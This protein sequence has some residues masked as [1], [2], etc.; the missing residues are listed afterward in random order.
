VIERGKPLSSLTH[1]DLVAYR[2]FL[3]DPQPRERWMLK[4]KKK[5]PRGHADWRPFAGTL[6]SNSVEYAHVVL[7]TCFKWLQNAGYLN[8]NPFA[9]VPRER[10]EPPRVERF[11][12]TEMW[13][14]VKTTI[15]QMP[16]TTQRERLHA[17]RCRWL[18]TVLYIGGLRASEVTGATMGSLFGRRDSKGIERWW[19]KVTGKGGKTRD[20]PATSEMMTELKRYRIANDLPPLPRAGEPVRPLVLPVIAQDKGRP[21]TRGALHRIIKEVFHRTAARV[22]Q[23]PGPESEAL[24]A[25]VE[26]ASA[27]WMRHTAGTQMADHIDLRFVRDNFGHNSI[28]TTSIYLHS[29]ANSRHDATERYHHAD[30][31][32]GEV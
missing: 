28:S 4:G 31:N 11:L 12:S 23:T 5:L 17:A 27:H 29:E 26:R 21:L 9:L 30:W 2:H 25:G 20:V 24:A 10:E 14:L 19:L 32:E 15:E 3:A 1:E 16:V 18:F 6:S 22:R 8:R 13:L 7:S